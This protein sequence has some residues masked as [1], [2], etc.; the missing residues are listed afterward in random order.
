MLYGKGEYKWEGV[1]V[2]ILKYLWTFMVSL[3]M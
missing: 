3:W 1:S 2:Y